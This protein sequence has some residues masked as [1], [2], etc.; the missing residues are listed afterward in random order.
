MTLESVFVSLAQGIALVAA[1]A[2]M[3]SWFDKLAVQR[4]WDRE[5]KR[6]VDGKIERVDSHARAEGARIER[7]LGQRLSQVERDLGVLNER[8]DGLPTTDD[9]AAFDRR[10]AELGQQLGQG[11]SGVSAKV[12]GM[13]GTV[14]TILQHILDSERKGRA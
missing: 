5:D 2:V 6:A 7:E 12:E 14:K 13:N 9:M 4:G 11:L 3:K 8:I 1:G 10:L